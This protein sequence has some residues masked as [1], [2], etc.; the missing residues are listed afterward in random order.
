M[1]KK[2]YKILNDYEIIL[3]VYNY[4]KN[5]CQLFFNSTM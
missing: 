3:L 1:D 4:Y 2:K 5:N